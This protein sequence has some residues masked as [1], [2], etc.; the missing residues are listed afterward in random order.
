MTYKHRLHTPLL[1]FLQ[2]YIHKTILIPI[3]L[4]NYN[5]WYNTSYLTSFYWL[6]PNLLL[7][8]SLQLT[9]HTYYLTIDNSLPINIIT[10]INIILTV[11]TILTIQITLVLVVHNVGWS[12]PKDK[13]QMTSTNNTN[14]IHLNIKSDLNRLVST[15]A[16]PFTH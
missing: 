11:I 2:Y 1:T 3:T 14:T 5:R 8:I 12:L 9:L 16:L 4:S 13:V 10:S 15:F 7:L 6:M